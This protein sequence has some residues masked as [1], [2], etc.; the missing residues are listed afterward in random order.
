MFGAKSSSGQFRSDA[1]NLMASP[2]SAGRLCLGLQDVPSARV[3]QQ[4][5]NPSGR[6]A[7]TWSRPGIRL[8]PQ[9]VT[10]DDQ[11]FCQE[12]RRVRMSA[13]LSTRR[14]ASGLDELCINTLRFLSVDAVQKADSGHPGLP[15]GAAPMAYVLW[16]RFLK[17][18]PANP[19]LARPRSLCPV[20]RARLDAAVQPAPPDRLRSFARTDQA[21]S[22]MGQHHA[23]SSRTRPHA[24]RRDDDRPAR[25][26]LRQRGRHGDGRGAPGRTLQPPR[27]R[28]HQSFHLRDRER[29]RPDGRRRV[30]SRIAG[31]PLAAWQADLSV[32][33]QSG[34]AFRR[35]RHHVHRR[36]RA[37]LRGLRLAH[38]IDRRRQRSGGHRAGALQRSR[39]N[40]ASVVDSGAHA[41]R[42][43]LAQQAGHLQGARFAA[44]RG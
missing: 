26:G 37:T 40:Q 38:P 4:D 24:R 34:H 25:P 1:R 35:H 23:G 12:P 8:R 5:P 41:S 7:R 27:L 29:R 33:R 28:D 11:A 22:P 2:A 42:L 21:V 36:P 19:A 3:M 39:R 43:R 9:F 13:P 17:H 16:T 14:S 30:G 44:G 15:L 18:H 31:R 6:F 10:R 32:R 20:C